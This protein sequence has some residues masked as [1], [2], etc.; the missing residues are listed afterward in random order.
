MS[1]AQ[2]QFSLSEQTNLFKINYYK[3]SA[4]M[5]NSQ[6]PLDGRI[7]KKYDFEGKQKFVAVPLSF[8]GGVGSGKL[9]KSNSGNYDGAIITSKRVYATCEIEREAIYASKSDKGAFVRATAETVKKAV[10]SY[11]RNM[12]RINFADGS[13]VL[14]RGDAATNVTG[15]GTTVSP[16]IVTISDASWLEANWEE[17]DYVQHVS[18]LGTYPD[19]TGG[20][21]EGGQT[22]TN[23]LEIV[24]VDVANKQIHLVGTSAALAALVAGTDPLPA[25]EG[26]CLQKSYLMD[27]VGLKTLGDFAD[28]ATG[29]L[30]NIPYQRRWTELVVD[31][32]GQGINP[33]LLNGHVLQIDKRSGHKV[34]MILASYEQYQNI[35]AFLEDEK[36]YNLPNRVKGLIGFEGIEYVANGKRIALFMDRFAQPDSIKFLNDE[37][38]ERHHRP[39]FGWFE[40]DG[41]VFLRLQDDDAYGA[42]YGG[43]MQNYFVPTPLGEIVNLAV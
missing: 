35:L 39:G 17:K 5:Y 20:S 8:S 7:K 6:N 33:D 18:G 32:G 31:A 22:E 42:R 25:D 9:P 4:N 26:L 1:L 41:T 40:D 30:Y 37:F 12:N 21:A 16:Y 34:N 13:A 15:A 11:M 23:L 27:P 2:P 14:G 29:T 10:E 43:Y 36:V 19:N 38:M 3:R 28:A 24:E